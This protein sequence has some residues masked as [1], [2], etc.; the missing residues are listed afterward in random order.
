MDTTSIPSEQKSH[1]TLVVTN[2]A[3]SPNHCVLLPHLHHEAEDDEVLVEGHDMH[4]LFQNIISS[5]IVIEL[6]VCTRHDSRSDVFSVSVIVAQLLVACIVHP[7]M[8]RERIAITSELRDER[9]G[10]QGQA[11]GMRTPLKIP[12]PTTNPATGSH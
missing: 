11:I 8:T 3:S 10:R 5:N 9:N 7:L 12:F 2:P 4:T 1:C 6:L